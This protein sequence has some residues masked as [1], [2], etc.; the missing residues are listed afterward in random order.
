MRQLHAAGSKQNV[1]PSHASPATPPLILVVDD[2]PVHQELH[3]MML[4]RAG[5]RTCTAANAV[6]ALTVF[7]ARSPA[8]VMTDLRMPGL[9]GLRMV[10]LLRSVDTRT[11]VL[12]VT[13][14]AREMD[15]RR[16]LEAGLFAL[17]PKP[18]EMVDLLSAVAEAVGPGCEPHFDSAA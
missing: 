17:L 11:P 2:E 3:C 6:E 13:S 7:A 5:Y 1:H 14:S 10:E 16:A 8:L 15:S 12:M 9:D 18:V 4:E